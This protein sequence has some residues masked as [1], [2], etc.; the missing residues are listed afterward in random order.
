MQEIYKK[1]HIYLQISKKKR[2]FA[3]T[4]YVPS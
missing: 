1:M 4:I 3:P 2:T